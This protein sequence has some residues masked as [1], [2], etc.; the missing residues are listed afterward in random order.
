MRP[1]PGV[2]LTL[3]GREPE[4]PYTGMLP[5]LIRGDYT[6]E[7]AHIDLAPLAA[8][9][10][11]RLILAEAT[12]IDLAVRRPSRCRAAP[13]SRSTCC[14]SMSAASRRCRRARA[15][16]SSRSGSSWR[17]WR[18]LEAELPAGARIAVVG[19]G[20]RRRRTGAG[21]GAPLRR[22]GCGSCWCATRA[23]PLATAPAMRGRVARH[24]A[25]GRRGRTG[26][27]RDRPARGRRQAGAVRRQ[28]PGGRDRALGDRG[29]GAG[30]PGRVRSGLRCGRLRAGRRDAA[31]RQ[32]SA[33]CSPPA[34]AL[35]SRA[36][37]GRKPASGRCAPARRWRTIC[38]VRRA[39]GR[40]GAGG[41]SREALVILGIGDGRA[42]AWRNGMAVAGRQV[43]RWKDWIDRRWM[44][45]YQR[46]D[47]ADGG[48][49]TRCAAAA[50]APR[51]APRCWRGR[52][53]DLPRCQA[54]MC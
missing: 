19:G 41:R 27:R 42:L 45:M 31:Q 13:I 37:R 14:R 25:G 11:A 10:R 8:T 48:A 22:A 16:R 5:G 15:C 18:R 7:Q 26:L 20:A 9:A 24:C 50:A 12:A 28:L 33:S 2:R 43:W 52:W 53:P 32:P 51:S 23:E 46:A 36:I 1:E 34:T 38:G 3:I 6:F 30:V 35:R 29:G 39:G 4:T 44:R 21:A 49:M 40:C 54:P 47:G 17:G